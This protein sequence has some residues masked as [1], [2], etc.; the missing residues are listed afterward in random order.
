MPLFG[1]RK[2]K[3][4]LPPS[5]WR[6]VYIDDLDDQI[7]IADKYRSYYLVPVIPGAMPQYQEDDRI[8]FILND[9]EVASIIKWK[10]LSITK[11]NEPIDDSNRRT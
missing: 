2:P 8:H 4:S 5:R 9:D 10:I 6:V 1:P 11:I 7:I 3:P